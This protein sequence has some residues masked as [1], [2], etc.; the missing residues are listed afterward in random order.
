MCEPSI[1]SHRRSLPHS[2]QGL[3]GETG[4]ASK[5]TLTRASLWLVL[6]STWALASGC[7]SP[8]PP[9]EL[10]L[11]RMRIVAIDKPPRIDV[12]S[13]PGGKLV[14]AGVGAGTGSGAGVL[15]AGVMCLTVGPLFPLCALAL[16]PTGGVVGAVTGGVAGAVRTESTTAID[17][18]TKVLHDHLEAVSYSRLLAERLQVGLADG[19]AIDGLDAATAEPG[20]RPPCTLDVAVT[21]VGTEGKAEFALRLVTRIS[22]RRGDDVQPVWTIAKE[23]QSETELTT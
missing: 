13:L 2:Q 17:L 22:L 14:G 21:E 11:S 12:N 18:K 6:A 15:V 4:M 8:P 20:R 9:P 5:G 7:A 1:S 3:Q 16:V 23:L 19:R 10:E